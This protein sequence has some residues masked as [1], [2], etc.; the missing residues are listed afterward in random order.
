MIK[1][2]FNEIR[3]GNQKHIMIH[4]ADRLITIVFIILMLIAFLW[5]PIMIYYG[6]F[7]SGFA[8]AGYSLIQFNK[9]QKDFMSTM[10]TTGVIDNSSYDKNAPFTPDG[11]HTSY[12]FSLLLGLIKGLFTGGSLIDKKIF[13]YLIVTAIS[14]FIMQTILWFAATELNKDEEIGFF[15]GFQHSLF[16]SLLLISPI[17][18]LISSH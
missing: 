14:F 13:Q 10:N 15:Y 7:I 1:S 9:T 8:V 11:F 5:T 6:M 17:F 4:S 2:I 3:E 12:M 18:I 16:I